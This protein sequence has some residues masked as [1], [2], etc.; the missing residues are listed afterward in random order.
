MPSPIK[1]SSADLNPK[2]KPVEIYDSNDIFG[3]YSMIGR[4]PTDT[5]DSDYTGKV[6][7]RKGENE[8]II[9]E[10]SIGLFYEMEGIGTINLNGELYV[11]FSTEPPVAGVWTLLE[12]GR[13]KGS[14]NVK[15]R[16]GSQYDGLEVWTPS[17]L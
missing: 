17:S 16:H 3:N 5:D 14:W 11:S 8:S 13:L 6:V 4:N 2:T 12:D 9:V 10:Q 15:T 7:I 1:H